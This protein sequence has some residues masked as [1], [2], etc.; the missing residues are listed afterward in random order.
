MP[1]FNLILIFFLCLSFQELI[2]FK[3]KE[4]DMDTGISWLENVIGIPIKAF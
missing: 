1:D 4:R 3:M 2:F